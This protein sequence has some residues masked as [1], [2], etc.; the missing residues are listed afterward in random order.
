MIPAQ[1]QRHVHNRDTE[2]PRPLR[3]HRKGP[4]FKMHRPRL[5]RQH[6]KTPGRKYEILDGEASHKGRLSS[7]QLDAFIIIKV[8]KFIN[9]FPGLLKRLDFLAVDTLCLEN[10]EEM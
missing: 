8:E 5:C 7:F 9:E 3:N 10:V 6:K 4:T 1:R 2:H